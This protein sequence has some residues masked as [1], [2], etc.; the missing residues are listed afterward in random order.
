M[1]PPLP[2]CQGKAR[3]TSSPGEREPQ[4]E[5]QAGEGRD[6]PTAQ[7]DWPPLPRTPTPESPRGS[8]TSLHSIWSNLLSSSSGGRQTDAGRTGGLAR[9]RRGTW[10]G[11]RG[12]PR[13]CPGPFP[14]VPLPSRRKSSR[15]CKET[16]G[17]AA[18]ARPAASPEMNVAFVPRAASTGFQA[19]T[20]P[21]VVPRRARSGLG[22]AGRGAQTSPCPSAGGHGRGAAGPRCLRLLLLPPPARPGPRTVAHPAPRPPGLAAVSREGRGHRR[23]RGRARMGL[24]LARASSCLGL[25]SPTLPLILA[26]ARARAG[27]G[28]CCSGWSS[29]WLSAVGVTNVPAFSRGRWPA[30]KPRLLKDP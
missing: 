18:S 1:P 4:T 10:T 3:L 22:P 14:S 5:S 21:Q 24:T 16:W 6:G 15:K 30:A 13:S 28:C 9:G 7:R 23:G 29:D 17:P 25:R 19:T 8:Q 11:G 2:R 26:R 20:S 27:G 12:H